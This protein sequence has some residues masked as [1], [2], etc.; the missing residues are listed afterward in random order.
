MFGFVVWVCEHGIVL[1][2]LCGMIWQAGFPA[3]A[4]TYCDANFCW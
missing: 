4:S 2:L 3:W 1:S